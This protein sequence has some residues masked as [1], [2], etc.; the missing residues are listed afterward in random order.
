MDLIAIKAV[1]DGGRL[2]LLDKI[3]EEGELCACV[4]PKFFGM[5]QPAGSQHLK[6]L[7]KAGLVKCRRDGRKRLYSLSR[8]GEIV[9]RDISRW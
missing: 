1:A 4:L 6:V 8:R 5:S 3:G 2:K 9:L 7:L